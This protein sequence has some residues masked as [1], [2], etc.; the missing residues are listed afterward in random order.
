MKRILFGAARLGSGVAAGQ[1]IVL[2]A[3]PLISRLFSPEQFGVFALVVALSG[4]LS[5]LLIGRLDLAIP[6]A[7]SDR[8]ARDTLTL[9]CLYLGVG[10][11]I[12]GSGSVFAY[13]AGQELIPVGPAMLLVPFVAAAGGM[14]EL[15]SGY[16]VRRRKYAAAG[17]RALLLSGSMTASQLALGASGSPQG[18]VIG[19]LIGRVVATGFAFRAAGVSFVRDAIGLRRTGVRTVASETARFP[20]ILAP[21]SLLNAA[22]VQVPLILLGVFLGPVA[23]GLFAFSQRI[24]SAPVA[25]LTQSLSQIYMAESASESRRTGS[26]SRPVFLR[27]SALLLGVSVPSGLAVYLASPAV[28]APLFGEE[29]ANA[30][31]VAQALSIG[32]VAQVVAVPLSQS[33]VI[34]DRL[35][36]QLAWDASRLGLT[37]IAVV[38]PALSGRTIV[39]VAFA[40][41]IASAVAYVGLWLMCLATLRTGR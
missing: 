3:S 19:H 22:G 18:L 20:L 5:I 40:Y 33:L 9:G 34:A 32:L 24:L 28:F 6:V 2:L 1:V 11:L 4:V 38:L 15:A 8:F 10:S 37:S 36:W 31:L 39:E 30:G 41:S 14:F 29:W 17:R 12:V 21:S 26:R 16:L 7:R 23:V 35:G 25:L 13:L 27:F